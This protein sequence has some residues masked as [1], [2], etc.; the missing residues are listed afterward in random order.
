MSYDKGIRDFHCYVF[1]TSH[2]VRRVR[3]SK[4]TARGGFRLLLIP[5]PT[6][7]ESKT[8]AKAELFFF[9]TGNRTGAYRS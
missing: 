4:S 9:F 6:K 5:Y 8:R 2:R 3:F 7:L 1:V